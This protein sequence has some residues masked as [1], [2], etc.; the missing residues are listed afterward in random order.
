[1]EKPTSKS[2]LLD[3]IRTDRAALE[4]LLGRIPANRLQEPGAMGD[5]TVKDV[6]AHVTAWERRLDEWLAANER[7][8]LTG[9]LIEQMNQERYE[10]DRDRPLADIQADF[11]QIHQN[12]V[13]R[14]DSFVTDESLT[15]PAPAAPGSRAPGWRLIAACTYLHYQEHIEILTHWLS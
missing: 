1:M 3:Q 5:W 13:H 4:A 9:E 2:A 10:Q 15:N 11:D 7:P 14:L 6:M 8:P 12:L